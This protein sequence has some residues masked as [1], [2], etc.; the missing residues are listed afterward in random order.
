MSETFKTS[1][2]PR[3]GAGKVDVTRPINTKYRTTVILPVTRSD[4][5]KFLY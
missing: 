4:S 1:E 5:V 2:T 3:A